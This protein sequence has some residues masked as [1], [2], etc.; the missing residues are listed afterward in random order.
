M[1]KIKEYFV[2]FLIG[3][4]LYSILEMLWRGYTHWTMCIAGGICFSMIYAL[5]DRAYLWPLAGKCLYG[6]VFITLI[7]F[8]IGCVVNLILDWNVWDY[9]L[10]RGNVMGQICP[11][12]T[13]LWFLLCIPGLYLAEVIR[14]NM[15][16][17]A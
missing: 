7:E 9:S 11:Q 3:G 5:N 1:F 16:R 12:F 15:R 17:I 8:Q 13:L 14:K 4:T 6:S 10:A 2:S